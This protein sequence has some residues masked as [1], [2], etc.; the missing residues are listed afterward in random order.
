MT[1][2]GASSG[3]GSFGGSGAPDLSKVPT[4]QGGSSGG[5]GNVG[6]VTPGS[7]C[8]T[9]S[10]SVAAPPVHLVFMIDRSGSMGNSK[11]AG[12]NLEVRWKPVALGLDAFFADDASQNVSASI[13]FFGQGDTK[14]VECSADTYKTPAVS[15]RKLPEA[16]AFSDALAGTSPKGGTPT[17][18]A[19]EGAI[20]YAKEVKAS[21]PAGER[22]AIV[23]ATDGDPNDCSSTAEN[24]A[25]VAAA[26]KDEIPTYVIGVG[27]DTTKLDTIAKGGGTD[28]AIMI[29]TSDP[30]QVSADLRAAV[31]QIKAQQLGCNYPLPAPPNGQTLDVN[32]VN[33]DYTPKGGALQTLAYSTDCANPNGWHYDNAATPKEVVMCRASCDTLKADRG[34]KLDIVFGCAIAAPPGTELPGGGVR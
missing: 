6:N 23:L 17:K 33:V 7:V 19:L 1:G 13:A 14:E 30:A 12:Q 25:E 4:L 11:Q 18:P 16:K 34:G 20:A 9:S 22:V 27:P 15:M 8:A 3:S 21:L 31:G 5:A 26:V 28:H 2:L 29:P 32:A 24:V 10:A